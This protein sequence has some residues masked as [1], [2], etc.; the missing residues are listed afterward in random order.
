MNCFVLTLLFPSFL[1]CPF[2]RGRPFRR[3]F[4]DSLSGQ[5]FD[6]LSSA[7]TSSSSSSTSS[8]SPDSP[9]L[10]IRSEPKGRLHQVLHLNPLHPL[11][12]SPY[13]SQIPRSRLTRPVVTYL[14]ADHLLPSSQLSSL[15][16]EVLGINDWDVG[17]ADREAAGEDWVGWLEDRVGR[18]TGGDDR[19]GEGG[20]EGWA[21]EKDGFFVWNTG[22]HW[23]KGGLHLES[24]EE[25]ERLQR[26]MVRPLFLLPRCRTPC[27]LRVVIN[28]VSNWFLICDRSIEPLPFCLPSRTS[29]HSTARPPPHTSIARSTL[30]HS[31]L[32]NLR[33]P[34]ISERRVE[35]HCGGGTSSRVS[36]R[37]NALFYRQLS[38]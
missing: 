21:G 38:P 13:L 11:F 23:G 9:A 20:D 3:R 32:P 15:V 5:H 26:A 24:Q 22:A 12:S 6:T 29:A 10:L 25:V 4:T 36:S 7:L 1:P 35:I 17:K 16:S 33:P 27:R 28:D 34:S 18:F 37:F 19:D 31:L 14:R 30:I 8:S 2:S